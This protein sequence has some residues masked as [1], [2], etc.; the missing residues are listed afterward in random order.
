MR[1]A[2]P[3]RVNEFWHWFESFSDSL[4]ES[5]TS[6]EL[7]S[8]VDERVRA[9]NPKLSWEIGPGKKNPWQ[10][11]ISPDMDRNLRQE[12]QEIVALAPALPKWEFY[13]A[14]QAKVWNYRFSLRRLDGSEVHVDASSWT[15]VLLRYPD[16]TC[17]VLLKAA[18]LRELDDVQRSHAATIVLESILGEDMV[19]NAIDRFELVD[20]LDVRFEQKARP[21]QH[22]HHAFAAS[23]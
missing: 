20:R 10:L 5:V 3:K 18:D 14:R 6:S 16:K 4:A 7:I 12:A 1:S 8:Q 21:I 22:L 13:S 11:V 17:E 2:N 15:F 9:L 19:L 23:C